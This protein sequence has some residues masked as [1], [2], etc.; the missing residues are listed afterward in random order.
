MAIDSNEKYLYSLLIKLFLYWI[1]LSDILYLSCWSGLQKIFVSLSVQ[2]VAW[3]MFLTA[4]LKL[5]TD[6][7]SICNAMDRE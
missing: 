1:Y 3:S 7:V 5:T 6:I 4:G 2:F